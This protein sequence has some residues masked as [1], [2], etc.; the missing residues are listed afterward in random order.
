[1]KELTPQ[2]ILGTDKDNFYIGYE[3][4]VSVDVGET[5][6]LTS[7]TLLTQKDKFEFSTALALDDLVQLLRKGLGSKLNV[8]K[9][10]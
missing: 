9:A 6:Y 8:S 7:I 1:M 2:D 5:G 10:R 4:I 3:E